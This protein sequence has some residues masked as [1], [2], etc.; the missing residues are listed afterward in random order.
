MLPVP[1]SAHPDPPLSAGSGPAGRDEPSRQ[2]PAPPPI[3]P[4][5]RLAARL[6]DLALWFLLFALPGLPDRL[7]ADLAAPASPIPGWVFSLWL[8]LSGVLYSAVSFAVYHGTTPGKWLLGL[9]VVSSGGAPVGFARGLGR[10][11]FFV[12]GS[13][14]PLLGL[15]NALWCL[16]DRP[17]QQCLHDKAAAT[18]VIRR[19]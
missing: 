8:P 10:E 5:R 1:E 12:F 17:L 18:H 6:V 3:T 9:R 4:V 7:F 14:T 11:V 19:S 13:L 16:W 2:S 15:V